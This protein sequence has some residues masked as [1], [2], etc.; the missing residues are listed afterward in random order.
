VRDAEAVAG[1]VEATVDQLGHIDVALANAGILTYAAVP[2]LE[3][4]AWQDM[5]DVN[6]TGVFH[7]ARA[8]Q[9]SR[10]SRTTRPAEGV[11]GFMKYL[12]SASRRFPRSRTGPAQST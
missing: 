8:V 5:L 11:I 3:L 7:M 1:A 9:V 12:P 2:D 6:L 4:Q 10:T